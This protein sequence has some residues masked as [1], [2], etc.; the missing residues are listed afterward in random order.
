MP[1]LSEMVLNPQVTVG[2]TNQKPEG[3]R[4]QDTR[5]WKWGIF[6]IWRKK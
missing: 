4:A 6:S 3:R 2:Q 5:G 1:D